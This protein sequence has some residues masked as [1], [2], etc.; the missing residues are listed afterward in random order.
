MMKV[1]ESEPVK[2]LVIFN[3]L[4]WNR[5]EILNVRLENYENVIVS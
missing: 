4:T 5:T 3:P 2:R 1:T